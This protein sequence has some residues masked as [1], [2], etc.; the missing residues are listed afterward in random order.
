[1]DQCLNKCSNHGICVNNKCYCV[2]GYSGKDC[3][4]YYTTYASQ[5]IGVEALLF[6][7][8]VAGSFGFVVGSAFLL[9]ISLKVNEIN[10]MKI[11]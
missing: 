6:A 1:V 5:G 2:S 8:I 7:T 9:M 3:S 11:K 10:F 4:L